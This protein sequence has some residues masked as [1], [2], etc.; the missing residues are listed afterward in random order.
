M[1]ALEAPPCG[2]VGRIAELVHATAL[3]KPGY[4][5]IDRFVVDVEMACATLRQ[6]QAKHARKGTRP[7][8]FQEN[9]REI[10]IG[11]ICVP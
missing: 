8:L 1:T 7:D 5:C 11:I 2:I 10:H 9:L 3:Q 6:D 4:T